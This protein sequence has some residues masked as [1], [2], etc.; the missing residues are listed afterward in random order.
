M[1]KSDPIERLNLMISAGAIATSALL[2]TPLFTASL[3]LGAALEVANYRALRRSTDLM[4]DGMISGGRT[5]SAGFGLRFLLLAVA[6]GVAIW[7]GA[8]PVALVVGL[9]TIVPAAI[10]G[11]WRMKPIDAPLADRPA[12]DDSSWDEWNPWLAQEREPVEEDER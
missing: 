7:A 2:A 4:F 10:V 9:S 5:W 8:H 12:P 1:H 6:M 11:A 3:A